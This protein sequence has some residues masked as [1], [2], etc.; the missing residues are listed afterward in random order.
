MYT[1][2]S[3]LFLINKTVPC[4]PT[5]L[6]KSCGDAL[7]SQD[8]HRATQ[9][10]YILEERQRQEAKERK[11]QMIEWVPKLFERDSI[12]GDWIYKH[13]EYVIANF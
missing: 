8:M 11:A 2:C 9:E 7:L 6:W 13:I 12:T 4:L 5:R 10:K 1:L 3:E